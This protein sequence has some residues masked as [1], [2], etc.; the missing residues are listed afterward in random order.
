MVNARI[1]I[2]FIMI[3]RHFGVS[4]KRQWIA[5]LDDLLKQLLLTTTRRE[6]LWP[7][8]KQVRISQGKH[9]PGPSPLEY[10][11]PR[12]AMQTSSWIYSCLKSTHTIGKQH[13]S[14]ALFIGFAFQFFSPSCLGA[15]GCILHHFL[16]LLP[17]FISLSFHPT[18]AWVNVP[19]KDSL[20]EDEN[21]C[22]PVCWKEVEIFIFLSLSPE[23]VEAEIARRDNIAI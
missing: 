5:S 2:Y 7:P 17:P 21:S 9:S 8:K 14:Q 12:F 11:G 15:C 3:S 23:R 20:G 10:P 4:N 6:R 16:L 13:P 19:M 18:A 22:W 1:Q